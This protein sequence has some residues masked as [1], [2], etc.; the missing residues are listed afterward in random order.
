MVPLDYLQGAFD[1]DVEFGTN[2]DGHKTAT[3]Y[4]I[5]AT[6]PDDQFQ[7]MNDLN[8]LILDKLGRGEV[9]DRNI[10]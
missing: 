8:Q 1:I 5:T 9:L 6:H 2:A 7:A 3:A 10:W 4:G